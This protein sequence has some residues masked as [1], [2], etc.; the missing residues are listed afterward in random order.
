MDIEKKVF[1]TITSYNLI[2]KSDNVVVALSG[3]K[4]STSIIYI[5]NKMGY[6]V[7]GLL[8]DLKLG[9]WSEIHNEKMKKFCSEIGVDLTIVDLK[10]EL[11]QG[12]CFIK[13]VL[14]KQKNLTGCTVCGIV[15]R[16]ILNK[17]AKNLGADKLV[18]GHNLDDEAQNVLMNFLK[19]NVLLGVNSSPATGGEEVKGFAQRV[20]PLFF[21]PESEIL[22][23][24]K[25]KNFDI[26]Y[27]KC[28]CAFGTYRVETREWMFDLSDL[29]KKKIVEGFQKIVPS[30]R[31]ENSC[32]LKQCKKCG[33]P[34]R[35]ELCNFCK[36]VGEI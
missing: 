19:G 24:A 14:K 20:K 4:D 28:P 33:E 12:I 27:D 30:L 16:W 35:G 18:T 23:Y 1:E 21:V 9:K 32:K 7:Q 10:K 13:A 3:G 8:I 26:L 25:K 36:I 2:K 29:E 22:K 15:K 17:W 11:G 6:N 5:L 34:S 31:N